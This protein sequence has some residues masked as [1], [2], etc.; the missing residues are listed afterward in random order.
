LIQTLKKEKIHEEGAREQVA[1]LGP[2]TGRKPLSLNSSPS[3]LFD[4]LSLLT[5]FLDG[6]LIHLEF[7]CRPSDVRIVRGTRV[8]ISNAPYLY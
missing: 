4:F 6:Q 7:D 8:R 1:L 3:E 2:E 5:P